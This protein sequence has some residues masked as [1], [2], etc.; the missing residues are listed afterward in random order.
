MNSLQLW[1]PDGVGEVEQGDDLAGLVLAA[2]EANG[3]V[4]AE[5]DIVVATSKVVSK[6][7]GNVRPD[8]TREAELASETVRVVARRGPTSIVRHRLGIT[9]AAAGI[10][11][12]NVD[13][14]SVV[15]LPEDPDASARALRAAILDRTGHNVGVLVTDTLGR[16][17]RVGQTDCAI[18]AAG[19]KVYEDFDGHV[20][21]YGNEL[22][23]TQPAVADEIA[24]AVELVQGKLGR[25]PFALV[26][27]RADLVLPQGQD[28][29]GAAALNRPEGED[30]FSVGLG[31]DPLP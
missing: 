18:G 8:T 1:A 13:K 9:L 12:S 31:G 27:G 26:R 10:D 28:G 29:L 20:D 15:L 25:R 2:F 22:H 4:L 17:W 6:A 30:L 5:G 21:P 14:G 11:A 23:V 24:G 7:E 3:L 19:L 16:A